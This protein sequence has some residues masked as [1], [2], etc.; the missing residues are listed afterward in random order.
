MSPASRPAAGLLFLA[1]VAWSAPA[2]AES[3]VIG[4]GVEHSFF[5]SGSLTTRVDTD[6]QSETED[7]AALNSPRLRSLRILAGVD[8][9][10]M[11]D[12]YLLVR[13][14]DG[15]RADLDDRQPPLVDLDEADSDVW[16]DFGGQVEFPGLDAGPVGLG[17][18]AELGGS[19][20][21]LE[22][23]DLEDVGDRFE[24]TRLR[25]WGVFGGG[26][27]VGSID[28]GKDSG[29]SL[30]AMGGARYRHVW[31]AE[32]SELINATT[33]RTTLRMVDP[34]AAVDLRIRI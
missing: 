14:S 11:T 31:L 21:A 8:A 25:C 22:D 30:V 32:Y 13:I 19:R 10:S 4:G 33:A 6:S 26:G 18:F 17:V 16:L 12:Q 29:V 2:A 24:S 7:L 1:T 28:I 5:G 27:L 23:S 9:D 15:V 34:S 20:V 3:W